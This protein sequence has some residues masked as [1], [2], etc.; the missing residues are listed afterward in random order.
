MCAK[1]DSVLMMTFRVEEEEAEAEDDPPSSSSLHG[2][3]RCGQTFW[4]GEKGKKTEK[5]HE[6]DYI[7]IFCVALAL[8]QAQFML[9]KNNTSFGTALPK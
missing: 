8:L 6:N 4:E 2:L 9:F 7:K 1:L 5:R 3:W